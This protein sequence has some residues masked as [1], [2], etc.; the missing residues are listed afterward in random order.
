[1]FRS[2]VSLLMVASVNTAPTATTLNL[3]PLAASHTQVTEGLHLSAEEV[4][5]FDPFELLDLES[6]PALEDPASSPVVQA[7]AALVMDLETSTV[8]YEEN[9]LQSLPMAS[10]TKIMTALIILENHHLQEIVT[11]KENFGNYSELGVRMWLHQNEQ[12]TVE[13]LLTGLLVRSAGDAAVTLANYHSGS[14][15]AF[16]KEMN[17]RA[18]ELN[19]RKTQFQNPI[20]LDAPNHYSSAFDLAILTKQALSYP[21][22]RRIVQMPYAKVTSVNEKIEHELFNTNYLLNSFLDIRGVKTGTT[23]AAGQSLINLAYSPNGN[24]V[25]VVLL[26]SPERFQESKRLIEWVFRNHDW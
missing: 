26:N 11:V 20:G 8:L 6:I 22:F 3:E 24:G 10:L 7:K 13:N 9:H 14:V 25:I 12:I 18:V 16:V 5:E 1:M 19:L 2:L 4:A 23:E 21:T 15:E 17:E